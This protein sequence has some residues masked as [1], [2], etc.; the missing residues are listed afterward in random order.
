M[1]QKL[2]LLLV[3]AGGFRKKIYQ[4]LSKGL[5]AIEPPFWAALTAGY[6]R[7]KNFN[8]QILDANAENL[9]IEESS[10]IIEDLN[11]TLTNIIA[12]G[13]HPS[14]ST[15]IMPVIGKLCDEI[16][17]K[18]PKRKIILTGLHPSALPKKTVEEENCDFV[19]QGK[20]F[21]QY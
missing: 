18:N 3:N 6:I 21:I 9:S 8:V 14:A 7:N 19:G 12:Y 1:S 20:G 15:A 5:S 17:Q 4:S 10:Q 16:K 13:Q 11:P 2:D